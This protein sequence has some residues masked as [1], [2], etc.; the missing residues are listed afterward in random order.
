LEK[1]LQNRGET[2]ALIEISQPLNNPDKEKESYP[3]GYYL[4]IGYA[5][6]ELTK[7]MQYICRKRKSSEMIWDILRFHATELKAMPIIVD[8][9]IFT[10][11][12]RDF[13]VLSQKELSIAPDFGLKNIFDEGLF[14]FKNHPLK[15]KSFVK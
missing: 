3:E 1:Q 10:Q 7:R 8:K 12:Y 9:K 2:M 11:I 5:N 4:H 15:D 13:K 14:Y 6:E